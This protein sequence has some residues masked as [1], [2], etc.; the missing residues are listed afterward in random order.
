MLISVNIDEAFTTISIL[1]LDYYYFF[2]ERGFD[3]C[4]L[5]SWPSS[6]LAFDVDSACTKLM[7]NFNEKGDVVVVV[8]RSS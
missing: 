7:Y 2:C 1:P 3:H 4:I 5:H 8:S 6:D